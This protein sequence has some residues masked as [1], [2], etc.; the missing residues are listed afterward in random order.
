M[1]RIAIGAAILVLMSA[2]DML[3]MG[4]GKESPTISVPVEDIS[5]VQISSAGR[6]SSV[7]DFITRG[8]NTVLTLRVEVQPSE[9]LWQ[10]NCV[11]DDPSLAWF[12]PHYSQLRTGDATGTANLTFISVGKMGN[13]QPAIVT[14]EVRVN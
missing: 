12:D 6:A 3:E 11:S 2:C 9:A 13:G 7:G 8:R 4:V 5:I 10:V 14:L 1:K